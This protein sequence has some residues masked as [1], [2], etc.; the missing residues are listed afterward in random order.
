MRN[1][2]AILLT[3][4]LLLGAATAFAGENVAAS[5]A[6][7]GVTL[8]ITGPGGISSAK[9]DEVTNEDGSVTPGYNDLFAAFVEDYPGVTIEFSPATW[10]DWMAALQTA[11]A[12]ESAD[13]VLHGSSITDICYDLTGYLEKDAWVY[14][15]LASWPEQFR[16]DEDN[17]TTW[18]PTGLS[19]CVNPYYALVDLRILNNYGVEAPDASWT[20]DDLLSIAQATTGTDPVTGKATYGCYPFKG[21]GEISKGYSSYLASQGIVNMH[22]KDYKWDLETT[23]GS[24]ENVKALEFYA[25]LVACAP[26]GFLE[27][28]G[29]DKYASAEND[30]AILLSENIAD[31]YKKVVADGLTSDFL[32]LPLPVNQ[33]EKEAADAYSSSYCG[34]SSIAIARNAKEPDLAWEF[35]KW[36]V[37]DEYAQEWIVKNNRCPAS[38]Y[39]VEYLL[40]NKNQSASF[41]ESYNLIMNNFWDVFIIDQ[42]DRVDTYIA[43]LN[44]I[45]SNYM[46]ELIKGNMTAQEAGDAIDMDF[47][48]TKMMNHR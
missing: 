5:D 44:S 35:I 16:A 9:P 4:A 15:Y 31:D 12:G 47:E 1:I 33:A 17:Y 22:Y 39:G 7:Q 13:V 46:G 21:L 41:T 25:D 26:G 11:V 38:K 14:D 6:Y 30:I 23:F 2:I 37:T 32:F 40:E 24:E 43:D 36:L 45:F 8:R 42:L 34:T 10:T 19:Y 48:E 18:Q 3:L 29:R 28:L 27:T 20:W